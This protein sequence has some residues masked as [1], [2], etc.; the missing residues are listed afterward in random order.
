MSACQLVNEI[1]YTFAQ[2]T[3]LSGLQLTDNELGLAFDDKLKVHFIY[4]PASESLQIE[5][6]V[7]DLMMVN[8]EMHRSFLAF[9]YHWSEHQLFFSLDNHRHQLCLNTF[10]TVDNLSYE[11]FEQTLT[12][13]LNHAEQWESLLA[14]HVD[15]DSNLAASAFS[16]L[17]V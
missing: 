17:R 8:I 16:E 10:I 6:E 13:L 9:N 4:H 11:N 12:E 1:F 3:G 5:A 7:T 14:T 15:S 2:Q